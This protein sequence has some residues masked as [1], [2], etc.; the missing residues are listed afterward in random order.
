[1]AKEENI[2]KRNLNIIN[3]KWKRKIIAPFKAS[4]AKSE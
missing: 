4:K 1:M 2:L 3:M